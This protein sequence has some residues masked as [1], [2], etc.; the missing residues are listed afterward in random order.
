MDKYEVWF[1]MGVITEI[2][3]I[4]WLLCRDSEDNAMSQ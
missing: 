4:Q 1:T 2:T 3:L